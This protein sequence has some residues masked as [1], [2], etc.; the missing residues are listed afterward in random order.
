MLFNVKKLRGCHL[1]GRDGTLGEMKEFYFD[2]Q[3]WAVRYLVADTGT[4]LTDRAVLISPYALSEVNLEARIIAVDLTKQQ[5]E[6]SPSLDTDV[7]VSR[8][9]ERAYYGHY[10]WPTYWD[11][12]YMWGMYPTLERDPG[13][14][15][16]RTDDSH[17]QD[18]HL[19]STHDVT[20]HH[21]QALDGEIGHVEDFIVDDET[22]ALRYLVVNTSNWW[23]GKKV[24]VSAAWIDSVSWSEGKV[25]TSLSRSAI[26]LAPEYVG[27]TSPTRPEEVVL[28]RHYDRPYYWTTALLAKS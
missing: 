9:F 21:I 14:W 28:H 1:Q 10:A 23:P 3:H 19:R 24:L 6:D 17:M 15:G 12:P 2:D 26:Q 7:P 22:W 16:V 20:G 4:W 11:G 25:M 8:Q 18:P 27:G 5:I 13:K